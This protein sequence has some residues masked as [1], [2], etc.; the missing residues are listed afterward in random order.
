MPDWDGNGKSDWHDDSI[1]NEIIKEKKGASGGDRRP[2]P[3]SGR[4]P[5]WF[6]ALVV[7]ALLFGKRW[8]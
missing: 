7:L 3:S 1:F 6:W 8:V 5:W 2:S 4:L